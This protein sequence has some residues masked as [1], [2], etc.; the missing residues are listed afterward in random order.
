[1]NL[2]DISQIAQTLGSAAVV[3]S[4]IFVGVQIRQN[5]KVTRAES[6]HAV[7]EALNQ[8]NLLWARSSEASRI[9]LAGMNDIGAL[10][11]ED[12]W[13]FDAMM[14]AYLHVCESMYTQAALGAGDYGIVVAE[15]DGIKAVFSSNG[16]REWW[17][18]NPFG[19]SPEFRRYVEKL[20][21]P[22]SP[23]SKN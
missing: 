12:R 19:F 22:E 20:T 10:T 7:S 5:T 6:H 18:E 11:P 3:A 14:R 16:I 13:R 15:E 17:G 23:E 9:W 2:A 4:L 21:N 8:V 1:M